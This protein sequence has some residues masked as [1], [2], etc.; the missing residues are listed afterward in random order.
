MPKLFLR[1]SFLKC[2]EQTLVESV[3]VKCLPVSLNRVQLL[4][5]Q[6][7]IGRDAKKSNFLA[8]WAGGS[9]LITKWHTA[10]PILW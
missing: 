5:P 9:F 6:A 7:C 10:I 2:R 8:V 4:R 1:C 3:I